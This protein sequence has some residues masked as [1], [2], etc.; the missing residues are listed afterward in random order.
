[1]TTRASPSA[2]TDRAS[3]WSSCSNQTRRRRCRGYTPEDRRRKPSP[4]FQTWPASVRTAQRRTT[5]HYPGTCAGSCSTRREFGLPMRKHHALFKSSR[6]LHD[7]LTETGIRKRETYFTSLVP[8]THVDL[9]A[10]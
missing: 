6:R 2:W 3:P 9:S 4:G 5:S 10:F 1:M 8:S 7:E